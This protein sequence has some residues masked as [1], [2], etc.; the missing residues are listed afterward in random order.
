MKPSILMAQVTSF[1]LKFLVDS[2]RLQ[3]VFATITFFRFFQ[4]VR[5]V[6]CR[7]FLTYQLGEQFPPSSFFRPIVLAFRTIGILSLLNKEITDCPPPQSWSLNRIFIEA[8]K[9]PDQN[10]VHLGKTCRYLQRN[11]L[12]GIDVS[13]PCVWW[14]SMGF[15]GIFLD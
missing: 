10:A 9:I 4:H 5:H 6:P 13:A 3:R 2:W 11:R 14:Q 15:S 7:A 1:G 12:S 8:L